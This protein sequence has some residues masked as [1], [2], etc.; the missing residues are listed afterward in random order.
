MSSSHSSPDSDSAR[1]GRPL[2]IFGAVLGPLMH[3]PSS[4]HTAG[5]QKVGMVIY[6]L[7]LMQAEADLARRPSLEGARPHPE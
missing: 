7:L 4:S 6:T 5:P 3:G 1:P 2:S